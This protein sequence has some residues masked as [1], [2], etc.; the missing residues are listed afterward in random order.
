MSLIKEPSRQSRKIPVVG[1][2]CLLGMV[3]LVGGFLWVALGGAS[4]FSV[5]ERVNL[6]WAILKKE[7]L[8]FLTT[9]RQEWQA[10]IGSTRAAWYGIEESQG[11]IMADVFYGFDMDALTEE[12][13]TV[14]EDGTV[15][16]NFPAPKILTLSLR[17]ESYESVT[18]RTGLMKFKGII[19]DEDEQVQQRLASLK[20]EV[21]MDMLQHQ[22]LDFK[23][24]EE[25]I[26]RF[27]DPLFQKMGVPYRIE[28]QDN[29]PNKAIIDYLKTQGS[30]S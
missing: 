23:E 28:F 26:I 7:N 6:T 22:S 25:G 15:V 19:D 9:Q 3:L 12:D 24:M 30:I 18:K 20:R 5:E 21:L 8:S 4:A 16:I 13:V 29:S 11:S 2:V 17:P 10:R 14:E 27:L 1:I